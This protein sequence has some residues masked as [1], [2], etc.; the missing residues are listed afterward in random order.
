M[1]FDYA[2][3][4]DPIAL[5]TNTQPIHVGRVLDDGTTQLYTYQYN[6]FGKVTQVIDP[7]GR[8]SPVGWGK[9]RPKP[10]RHGLALRSE[11][12][13]PARRQSVPSIL[14]RGAKLPKSSSSVATLAKVLPETD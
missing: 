3:Q 9:V 2:G 5:G 12:P 8:T 1:G 14:S 6:E 7:A 11:P 10:P 13:P 4:S